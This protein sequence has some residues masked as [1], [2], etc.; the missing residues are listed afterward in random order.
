M[1]VTGYEAEVGVGA[2]TGA[3]AVIGAGAEAD[4]EASSHRA[5]HLMKTK[6]S[7]GISSLRCLCYPFSKHKMGKE[8]ILYKTKRRRAAG[9]QADKAAKA[10]SSVDRILIRA[11]WQPGKCLCIY[12]IS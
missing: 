7:K 2:E 9:R 8:N 12:K 10:A 4:A 5:R 6:M 11:T 3:K 1:R